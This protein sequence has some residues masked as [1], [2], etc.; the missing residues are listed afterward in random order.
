[1]ARAG[2][3]QVIVPHITDQ[4]YWAHRVKQLGVGVARADAVKL[5]STELL[6]ALREGLHPDVAVRAHAL[7]S[8]IELNGAR[9]AAE[10]ILASIH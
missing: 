1:V 10:K 7:A 9:I 3:P 5:T 4:Y 8:R 6:V 2:K